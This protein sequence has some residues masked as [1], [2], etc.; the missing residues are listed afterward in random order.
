MTFAPPFMSRLTPTNIGA[1]HVSMDTKGGTMLD[2][3]YFGTGEVLELTGVPREMFQH[4][5]KRD[6][7]VGMGQIQGGKGNGVRRR[8]TWCNLV[9][10][11][12]TFEL[13]KSKTMQ[14]A[15]AFRAVSGL[16]HTDDSIHVDKVRKVGF[17][18]HWSEGQTWLYV[19]DGHGHIVCQTEKTPLQNILTD[20]GNPRVFVALNYSSIFTEITQRMGIDGR[21]ALDELY[22]M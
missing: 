22:G 7:L 11:A 8:F 21:V 9:E 13:V 12:V 10:I 16:A 3:R 6:L 5:L 20:I 4:W 18:F 1:I 2:T 14:P 15:E 19:V 17:P